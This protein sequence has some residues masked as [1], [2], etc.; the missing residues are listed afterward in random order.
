MLVLYSSIFPGSES[1]T[2][3]IP[4]K[5]KTKQNKTKTHIPTN[6]RFLFQIPPRGPG[7]LWSLFGFLVQWELLLL[8]HLVRTVDSLDQNSLFR[9][10]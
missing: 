4:T 10:F 9:I 3:H 2:K 8:S 6:G 7:T 1:D 5:K